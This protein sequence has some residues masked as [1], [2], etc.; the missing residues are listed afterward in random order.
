MTKMRMM[1]KKKSLQLNFLNQK[2]KQND[3]VVK[4][5]LKQLRNGKNISLIS[6]SLLYFPS[7][8]YIT[9][10]SNI[11]YTYTLYTLY[12]IRKERTYNL[13]QEEADEAD[14]DEEEEERGEQY[15]EIIGEEEKQAIEAVERRHESMRERL[16]MD[17]N[18]IAREYEERARQQAQFEKA[19]DYN[20]SGL[21]VGMGGSRVSTVIQQ[22]LLPSVHDPSI[23]RVKVKTG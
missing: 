5:Q 21:P 15:E 12:S 3:L 20:E 18:V 9:Y 22:S 16:S 6:T 8:L 23:W 2:I 4:N 10:T 11:I 19:R 7:P 14:S 13:F 1:N 17:A